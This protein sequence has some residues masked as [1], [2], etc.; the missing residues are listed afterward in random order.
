[1]DTTT[2]ATMHRPAGNG[3]AVPETIPGGEVRRAPLSHTPDRPTVLTWTGI[4]LLTACLLAWARQFVQRLPYV[5]GPEL[6]RGSGVH[7]V[8]EI[9]GRAAH[10]GRTL[11][12]EQIETVI[13]EQ[14]AMLDPAAAAEARMILGGYLA[15]GGLP[16]FPSDATDVEFERPFAIDALGQPVAWDAADAIFRSIWDVVYREN[17][18]SLAVVRDYKTSWGIEDPGE[19]MRLYAWAACCLWPEVEEVVVELH[20]VRYGVVR[21]DVLPREDVQPV[22]AAMRVRHAEVVE[23][24]ANLGD[25]DNAAVEK[26]FPARVT[27]ACNTCSYTSSCPKMQTPVPVIEVL[28]GPIE[29]AIAANALVRLGVQRAALEKQLAAYVE[30]HG[31]VDLGDEV[32]GPVPKPKKSAVPAVAAAVLAEHGVT[33][34]QLWEAVTLPSANLNKLVTK[35][36]ASAPKKEKGAARERVVAAIDAAGGFE[37]RVDI[38]MRRT[39]RAAVEVADE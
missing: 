28:V 29:A 37:H 23:R 7:E 27:N 20:F 32:Y 2:E 5:I 8:L 18:G 14:T 33:D 38:E 39:K 31:P 17:G 35:A 36:I 13:A 1:M 16:G 30:Q 12:D 6:Q 25:G 3:G 34:E 22:G 11:S 10:A 24:L 19:Q 21:R 4:R 9:L 26:A 15:R